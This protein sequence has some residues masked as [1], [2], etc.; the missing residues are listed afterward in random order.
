MWGSNMIYIEL[1]SARPEQMLVYQEIMI[2]RCYCINSFCLLKTL[3]FINA[4]KS[5]IFVNL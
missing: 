1:T 5:S 3:E 4:L 2:D